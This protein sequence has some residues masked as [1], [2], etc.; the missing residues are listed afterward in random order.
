MSEACLLSGGGARHPLMDGGRN[1][2]DS[3]FCETSGKCKKQVVA[4]ALGCDHHQPHLYMEFLA[5][6][7]LLV[8]VSTGLCAGTL[9]LN[10][11]LVVQ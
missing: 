8:A 2:Y 11:H 6:N 5:C 7:L 3:A 4:A 1:F 10:S 9:T